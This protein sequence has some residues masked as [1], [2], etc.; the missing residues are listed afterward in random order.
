M[1]YLKRPKIHEGHSD[2]VTA[3]RVL[4]NADRGEAQVAA[5]DRRRRQLAAHE[6]EDQPGP[7]PGPPRRPSLP[8]VGVAW[9]LF[10]MISRGSTYFTY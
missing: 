4:K 10:D 1:E 7:V 3:L 9:C 2:Y 5:G 6:L 8:R